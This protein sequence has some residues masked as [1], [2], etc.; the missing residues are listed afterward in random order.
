MMVFGERVSRV[1]V[2]GGRVSNVGKGELGHLRHIHKWDI[3]TLIPSLS[4]LFCFLDI[5]KEIT[6]STMIYF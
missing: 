5:M 4:L 3:N 6:P 1:M 2:L